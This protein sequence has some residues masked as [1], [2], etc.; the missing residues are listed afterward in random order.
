LLLDDLEWSNDASPSGAKPPFPMSASEFSEPHMRAVFD[1]LVRQHPSF[2]E[3]RVQDGNWG[4]AKKGEGTR[5]YEVVASRSLA[6][7]A[8]Q[9]AWRAARTIS[10]KIPR[11]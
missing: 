10:A 1:L 8:M 6:G 7:L 9:G 3:F 4:W 11:R 2:N 5:R